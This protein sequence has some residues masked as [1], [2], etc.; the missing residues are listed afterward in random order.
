MKT[1]KIKRTLTL[2]KN[3]VANLTALNKDAV[4]AGYVNDGTVLGDTCY[5]SMVICPI[6]VE[7]TDSCAETCAGG[8]LP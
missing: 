4:R 3:T 8:T 5:L 7:R 2:N 6:T 1:K